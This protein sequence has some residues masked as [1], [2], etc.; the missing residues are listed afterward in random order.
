MENTFIGRIFS[1]PGVFVGTRICDCCRCLGAGN[2][3]FVPPS[4]EEFWHTAKD[5][6]MVLA[7]DVSFVAETDEGIVGFM[8]VV[9]AIFSV[10]ILFQKL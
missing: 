4:W 1:K 2:W 7:P 3:G 9:F 5:L 8:L 6:K 10:T